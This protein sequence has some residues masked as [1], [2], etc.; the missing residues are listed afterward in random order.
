M[1]KQAIK[2]SLG[3]L[4][5]PLLFTACGDAIATGSGNVETSGSDRISV[6]ALNITSSDDPHLLHPV[7]VAI[8]ADL[9]GEAYDA[10]LLIA[11]RSSDGEVGCVLGAM[12]VTHQGDA[13]ATEAGEVV[14]AKYANEAE[15]VVDRTCYE[16]VDRDDIELFASF[17]PWNLLGDR[18]T[19]AN[20]SE[21]QQFDVY[22]MVEA[23]ALSIEACETCET[24]YDVHGT[25]GMDAQLQEVNLSSVVAVLPVAGDSR[26]E[27]VLPNRPDLSVTALARVTGMAKGEGLDEGRVQLRY[28]IRPLG[29]LDLGMPLLTSDGEVSG[30]LTLVEIPSHGDVTVSRPLYIR[31]ETR[32]VLTRGAWSHLEEFELVTCIETDFDQAIYAGE[33]VPRDN[34][35]GAVPLVVLREEV[36]ADGH[37]LPNPG[38]TTATDAEVWSNSWGANSGYGFGWSGLTFTAWLDVNGSDSATT[39]YGGIDVHNPGSWFE[40]GILATGTVF[41]NAVDVVDIFATFIG[42][43]FGGGGVAMGASIFMYEFIPEFEIQLSDGVPLSLQEMLDAADLDIETSLTK[44]VSLAGVNF[45]DGCGSVTAGL[46]LEG[47][48]G[49]DTD[50]TT[51]TASTTSQGIEVAGT[52][53]P[54]M[55]IS[56]KAGTTV[57]Y[58]EY[59]SG[60]ITATLN[61]LEIDVPFTVEVEFIDYAPLD[62]FRLVFDEYA[63]AFLTTL[64]GDITFDIEWKLWCSPLPGCKG[65][66][67]HTIA[68]WDGFNTNVA[69]FDLR[70]V[71]SVGADKPYPGW[72]EWTTNELHTGDFNADGAIDYLCH[73]V[74]EGKKWIDYQSNGAFGGTD[75]ERWPNWCTGDSQLVVGDFDGD[76]RDDM[77]C[78]SDGTQ[79]ID[80]ADSNAQFL[81]TDFSNV[82]SWCVHDGSVLTVEDINNDG[83]DDLY[84]YD[85]TG[86][87]WVD[88]ADANGTF[89]GFD[90][91]GT[92]LPTDFCDF[93]DGEVISLQTDHDLYVSARSSS[94]SWIVKQDDTIG[95]W[96]QF[97]VVCTGDYVSFKTAHNRYLQANS[98]TSDYVVKQQTSIGSWEKFTAIEQDGSWAFTTA[99]NR[100]LQARDSNNGNNWILKQ[101]TSIG[102]WEKFVV[103]PQ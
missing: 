84:C 20:D 32:D 46:W 56:A 78:N 42:Y 62:A 93:Y 48:L 65:D 3:A 39:T 72:C 86:Y 47:T 24:H 89:Y 55:D 5:L 35:C 77:L 34:D 74:S 22:S 54:F 96:E 12:S 79:L 100:Y 26:V 59:V 81:G 68:S 16:L 6:T 33:A 52:V 75:W 91:S 73:D 83:R 60:G 85:N 21:N 101:A 70:Q 82:S 30:E 51:I 67:D 88:Y 57:N 17:D 1:S 7:R 49:I 95:S 13:P 43:D 63:S 28:R 80:F 87:K 64:S 76:G 40:A 4:T 45:D 97:T 98:S 2:H 31:D 37:P 23:A 102:S 92:T 71:V 69:L 15:F 61:L 18:Q 29:S 11:M 36:G 8:E 38:A 99:H 44:S 58:S 103:V 90:W 27:P 41:D 66:H 19:V 50:E 53:T 14:P 9:M 10:D 94:E 25:P